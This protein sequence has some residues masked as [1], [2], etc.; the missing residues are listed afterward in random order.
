MDQAAFHH[1]MTLRDEDRRKWLVTPG[2]FF[3][4]GLQDIL[5]LTGGN[6]THRQD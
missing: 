6:P 1:A 4:W 2:V 5:G 3:A